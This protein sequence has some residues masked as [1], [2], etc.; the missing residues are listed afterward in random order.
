MRVIGCHG[1]EHQKER[2]RDV[3]HS[4]GLRD[5]LLR[6]IIAEQHVQ[7]ELVLQQQRGEIVLYCLVLAMT[8]YIFFGYLP[9]ARQ[10]PSCRS[11]SC[12]W[13]ALPRWG[14][15]APVGRVDCSW[16]LCCFS[17]NQS[18]LAHWRA[19]TC[20]ASLRFQEFSRAVQATVI[21]YC[22]VRIRR[23]QSFVPT[24]WAVE[25]NW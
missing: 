15:E 3:R 2:R 16:Q 17:P 19:S 4:L 18:A 10:S 11:E 24:W 8:R 23:A 1:W 5:D 6:Y 9:R 12:R 7:L 13:S 25:R 14:V 22:D 21:K 20:V